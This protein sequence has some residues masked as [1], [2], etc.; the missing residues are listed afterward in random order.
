MGKL[1]Y[2]ANIRLPTEKAHGLQIMKTCEA[3][4]KQGIEVELIVADRKNKLKDNPFDFYK[5]EKLFKITTLPCLDFISNNFFGALAYWLESITFLYSLKKYLKNKSGIFYT[6]DLPTAYYLSGSSRKLFYEIHDL[7]DTPA[8]RHKKAWKNSTGLVVISPGLKRELL[9][10]IIPDSKILVAPD[11]VDLKQFADVN[12]PQEGCRKQLGLPLDKRIVVYTGHLYDWKGAPT[13]ALAT[14]QLPAD[15]QVYLVG[16]TEKDVAKFSTTYRNVNNLHVVGWRPNSE[17]PFWQKAGDV[18]VL[19]NSGK[20]SNGA[21]YTS[22]LKLYEYMASGTKL[23][24]SDVPAL[25]EILTDWPAVYFIADNADSLS[26]AIALAVKPAAKLA[27]PPKEKL[28][29]FSWD[30][31]AERIKA[32][33]S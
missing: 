15:I 4:A 32:F 11:A 6:R 17:M 8:R 31:R 18:L 24:V 20:N 26:Q 22:P 7:P 28:A 5:V 9:K 25:K 30:Q 27:A 10:N 14:R 13:L 19:P 12:L 29:D 21:N 1:Y 2:L 23:V 3:L 33:L 16:G